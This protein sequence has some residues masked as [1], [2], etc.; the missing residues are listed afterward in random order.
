MDLRHGAARLDSRSSM[1][2]LSVFNG[3]RRVPPPSNE[4]VRSYAP[5]SAERIAI[6]ARL[7]AMPAEPIDIPLV[8]GG[9][10]VRTGDTAPSVMPH[11]HAHVLADCHR[12]APHHIR[13]AVDAAREA[14]GSWATWSFDDRAA[15]FLKAAEL[16]TTTWRDTVN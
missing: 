8:I 11:D 15:V 16:L 5:G 7:K 2:V 12:A 10:D 4:P 9:A 6:K 1:P 13:R 14:H 3:H